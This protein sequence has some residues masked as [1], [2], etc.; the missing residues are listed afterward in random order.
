MGRKNLLDGLITGTSTAAELTA[1]NTR[2]GDA[3]EDPLTAVNADAPGAPGEGPGGKLTAV[4]S[5]GRR[6]PGTAIGAVGASIAALRANAVLEIDPHL[7]EGGGL[8]DRLEDDPAADA[9]LLASIRDHGQQVPVLVRPHE[10]AEGRYR[11]VYG[12]RRVLAARDLGCPVKALV[13]DLDMQAAVLAQGQ[14]NTQRRDLSFIEKAHF[15]RQM[16]DAG[17]DRAAIC[18]AVNV[19]KT[20]ISRMLS[21]VD[22]LPVEILHRIGSA[23][24]IGRDRW[25]ALADLYEAA[26]WDPEAAAALT[27]APAGEQSSDARFDA[28]HAA[29]R[30]PARP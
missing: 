25:L 19:D 18:D 28:L 2:A 26:G 14:E 3:A 22:R 30:A 15:A 17:Y 20:V 24:G 7:I 12:R 11:I 5:G 16:R 8:E 4:N 6:T 27:V 13:R 23:P 1:V 9:A 29:F 21:V 10:S